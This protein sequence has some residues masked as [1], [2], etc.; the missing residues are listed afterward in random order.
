V[1]H[2]DGKSSWW[3][4]SPPE[5]S[6][7]R[8]Q[9]G[10]SSGRHRADSMGTRSLVLQRQ[11]R[12]RKSAPSSVDCIRKSHTSTVPLSSRCFESVE[13]A[14]LDNLKLFSGQDFFSPSSD[15]AMFPS[16]SASES[17]CNMDTF[18]T[19]SFSLDIN[20][21][22]S[23]QP[24]KFL[25]T[26]DQLEITAVELTSFHSKIVPELEPTF[27]SSALVEDEYSSV[28][29]A[30]LLP[31]AW[32]QLEMGVIDLPADVAAA[33]VPDNCNMA[34]F[35]DDSMLTASQLTDSS[36]E[37]PV[38][39]DDRE[40][41]LAA[42]STVSSPSDQPSFR[43]GSDA[44]PP[45]PESNCGEASSSFDETVSNLAEM[46]VE[47][48]VADSGSTAQFATGWT[49]IFPLKTDDLASLSDV[50]MEH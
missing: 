19:K 25:G 22:L 35:S 26:D 29:S 2:S 27:E 11:R 44:P 46:K 4:V 48:S 5:T 34:L 47:A 3:T 6:A 24:F 45:S 50:D 28:M 39:C 17:L 14:S 38:F 33:S 31:L 10:S 20:S 12:N 37:D 36:Q 15:N 42:Y 23:T 18:S 7:V 43:R 21:D 9:H 13:E 41:M 30:Q 16:K 49:T 8:W 1:P 40:L 32:N